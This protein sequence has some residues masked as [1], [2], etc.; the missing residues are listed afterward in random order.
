MSG[1]GLLNTEAVFGEQQK[2]VQI[3]VLDRLKSK[4]ILDAYLGLYPSLAASQRELYKEYMTSRSQCAFADW[5][6]L[7]QFT[8]TEHV[9]IRGPSTELRAYHQKDIN[10]RIYFREGSR[11]S[12][13]VISYRTFNGHFSMVQSS[14]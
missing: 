9:L 11:M 14:Q 1:A 3:G 10:D 7:R 12:Q 8:T 6:P 13:S 5:E 2:V 4:W